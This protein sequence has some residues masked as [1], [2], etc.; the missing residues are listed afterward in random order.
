MFL[1]PQR[2][3]VAFDTVPFAFNP[4][5]KLFCPINGFKCPDETCE[6]SNYCKG[7]YDKMNVFQDEDIVLF[8]EKLTPGTYCLPKGALKCHL[9][10]SI[11]V[12]SINDWTCVS[13]NH[14]I[15]KSNN[16]IACKNPYA[17][18]NSL[19]VLFDRQTNAAAS[20][21]AK[22]YY[23][24]F[25]GKLRY[26]CQCGSLDVRGNKMISLEQVPF[27][28]VSDYCL[29]NFKNVTQ[30]IGWK[31]GQCNCGP[32]SHENPKDLTSP[33]VDSLIG[34][35]DNVFTGIVKCTDRYSFKKEPIY[36]DMHKNIFTFEKEMTFHSIP[37]HFLKIK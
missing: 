23:E 8:N 20:S 1:N 3:V 4:F 36:C 25:N 13:R 17:K 15:W 37:T 19:N 9:K 22:D 28:C 5:D 21:V 27:T 26:E 7:N 12:Y 35:K 16:F 11:P 14:N 2:N 32:Y 31:N 6:C 33:C 30:D 24:M 29:A 34:M 18:D 10:S